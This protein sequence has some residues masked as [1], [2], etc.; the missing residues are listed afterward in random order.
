MLASFIAL[1]AGRASVDDIR[2]RL[3]ARRLA[4]SAAILQQVATQFGFAAR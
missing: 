1:L 4:Q 2:D 3:T